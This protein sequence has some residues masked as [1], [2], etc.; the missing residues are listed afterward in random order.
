[1]LS[2]ERLPLP[3]PPVGRG[4]GRAPLLLPGGGP[5]GGPFTPGRI[6][7]RTGRARFPSVRACWGP[8]DGVCC[9]S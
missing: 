7:Q 3:L 6:Q 8:V 9:W 2:G 1:M 5:Y 4:M